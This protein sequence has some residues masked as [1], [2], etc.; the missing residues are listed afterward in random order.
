MDI[1]ESSLRNKEFNL[2]HHNWQLAFL[3]DHNTSQ[4]ELKV[5]HTD[6]IAYL[7]PLKGY[8]RSSTDSSTF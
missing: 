8:W 2:Y 6:F 7:H 5:A 4:S 3:W 1:S